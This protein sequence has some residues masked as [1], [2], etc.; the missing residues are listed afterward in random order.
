MD[1]FYRVLIDGN[2]VGPRFDDLAAAHD[3]AA[4]EHPGKRYAVLTIGANR[5]GAGK[6]DEFE[7]RE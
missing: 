5:V 2:E 7:A 4:D 6:I 1:E 3:F